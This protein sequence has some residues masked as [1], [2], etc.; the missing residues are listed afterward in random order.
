MTIETGVA[1]AHEAKR[2]LILAWGCLKQQGHVKADTSLQSSAQDAPAIAR[3][4]QERIISK[5]IIGNKPR[6]NL[7]IK[8]VS[9]ILAK[10]EFQG[11]TE[12]YKSLIQEGE[13]IRL[14]WTKGSRRRIHLFI[15]KCIH[16][17]LIECKLYQSLFK[18]LRIQC[19][20]RETKAQLLTEPIF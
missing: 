18:D 15:L 10:L 9:H 2:K 4:L 20:I 5:G 8:T 1:C 11:K 3:G 12:N 14:Y 6:R 7:W 16:M 13:T 17:L 19:F